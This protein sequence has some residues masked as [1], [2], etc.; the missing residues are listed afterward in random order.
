MGQQHRVRAK[1]KR[2][3]AYVRRKK[4]AV[5]S[6]RREPLREKAKKPQAAPE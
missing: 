6:K 2:R 3:Q 4:A 5:K 1:R